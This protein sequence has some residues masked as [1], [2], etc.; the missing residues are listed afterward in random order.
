MSNHCL[1][2]H[3]E[4]GVPDSDPR[5]QA[6]VELFPN[7]GPKNHPCR[8]GRVLCFGRTA[9][10]SRSTQLLSKAGLLDLVD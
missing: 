9:G 1:K 5:L 7:A 10:Q 3:G 8:H 2:N 6:G 4:S